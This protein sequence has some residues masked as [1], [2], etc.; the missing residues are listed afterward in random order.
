MMYAGG[1]KDEPAWLTE[2]VERKIITGGWGCYGF[3]SDRCLSL[4]DAIEEGITLADEMYRQKDYEKALA[5]YDEMWHD[6]NGNDLEGIASK[7]IHL[8][9]GYVLS[10][11]AEC[12]CKL[13]DYEKALLTAVGALV[14]LK[15]ARSFKKGQVLPA[16]VVAPHERI[17]L[18]EAIEVMALRRR[19]SKVLTGAEGDIAAVGVEESARAPETEAESFLS[20]SRLRRSA[21]E[22]DMIAGGKQQ[23]GRALS[24]PVVAHPRTL[25]GSLFPRSPRRRNSRCQTVPTPTS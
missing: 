12:E 25:G 21:S 1:E 4:A 6:A 3:S 16:E 10:K 13:G 2:L 20:H 9:R 7:R 23:R 14:N 18:N 17:T 24:E 5:L 22:E 8:L 15:P 11:C 19:L